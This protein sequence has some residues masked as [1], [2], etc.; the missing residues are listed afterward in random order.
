MYNVIPV[1]S[2]EKKINGICGKKIVRGRS[3][4]GYNVWSPEIF[5][6][7]ETISDGK[8][9]IRG[10]TNQEIRRTISQGNPDTAK[11]RGAVAIC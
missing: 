11:G 10:F 1:Q 4:T 7:F 8:Y 6:L 3:Y 2:I 5:Q 9:L